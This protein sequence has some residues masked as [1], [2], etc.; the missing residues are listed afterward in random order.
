MITA[1]PPRGPRAARNPLII[2]LVLLMTTAA[3]ACTRAEQDRAADA[4]RATADSTANAD[5]VRSGAVR[6]P[7]AEQ[8]AVNG[9]VFDVAYVHGD[10]RED[11]D[12]KQKRRADG[13]AA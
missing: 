1:T 4:D 10:V 2:G 3:Q 12:G 13:P 9:H 6:G 11:D 8:R 5:S 7:R